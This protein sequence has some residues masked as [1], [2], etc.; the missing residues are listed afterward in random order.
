ME[1][2]KTLLGLNPGEVSSIIRE[3]GFQIELERT[4]PPGRTAGK[5]NKRVIALKMNE[6]QKYCKIIWC[7]E[8][9]E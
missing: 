5:G 8:D 4:A 2:F 6:E 1:D 3:K 7:F 9:Y